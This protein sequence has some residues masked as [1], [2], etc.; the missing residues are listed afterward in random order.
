L[1]RPAL[2]PV[3]EPAQGLGQ[4]V[5]LD[6]GSLRIEPTVETHAA[7]AAGER[8]EFRGD[9]RGHRGPAAVG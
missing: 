7:D 8:M 1:T 6:E 3:R 4:L 2:Q 5:A 9:R